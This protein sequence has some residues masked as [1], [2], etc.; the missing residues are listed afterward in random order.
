MPYVYN[1]TLY[2]AWAV[3]ILVGLPVRRIV[4]GVSVWVGGICLL[5]CCEDPQKSLK[6]FRYHEA[7]PQHEV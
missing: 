4:K 5:G 3:G 2:N 1:P 6:K 7:L